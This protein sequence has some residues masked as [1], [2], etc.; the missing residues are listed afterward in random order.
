MKIAD[1]V[2]RT[3]PA[4]QKSSYSSAV[5]ALRTQYKLIAIKE[6]HGWDFHRRVQRDES[7]K[8]LGME[9]QKL[10]HKAFPLPGKGS[11][12]HPV[13]KKLSLSCLNELILY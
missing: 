2:F 4:E 3:L 11:W 13:W 6:L 9:L 7:I 12:E 5:A 10:G 1:Q 8:K